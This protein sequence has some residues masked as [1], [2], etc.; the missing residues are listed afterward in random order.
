MTTHTMRVSGGVVL[1]FDITA[2]ENSRVDPRTQR[3][4]HWWD[5]MAVLTHGDHP[6]GTRFTLDD[7]GGIE[8]WKWVRDKEAQAWAQWVSRKIKAGIEARAARR[9]AA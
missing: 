6:D 8:G 5:G 2:V 7:M 3:R 9:E 1:S 4:I